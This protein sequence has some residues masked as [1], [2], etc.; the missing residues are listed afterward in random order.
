[1]D[2]QPAEVPKRRERA[3]ARANRRLLLAVARQR[4][5][6]QGVAD[7]SMQEIARAAGVGQG[8]LYRHFAHKG[9][10]CLALAQDDIAEF[11]ARLGTVIGD[12]GDGQTP[13][14][15]LEVLISERVQLM[16]RHLPL[17]AAMDEAGTNPRRGDRFRGPFDTWV[18]EQVVALLTEAAV[19]KEV[20]DL[21]VAV[22]ADLILA[23][24]SAALY[25]YQRTTCGYGQDR[26]VAAIH[27]MCIDGLRHPA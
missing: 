18:Y 5:A 13:L 7:T 12:R 2:D 15:R 11:Q 25:R 23:T 3:D 9:E 26:I 8:T 17:F 20:A 19:H 4:F 16:E 10:L 14:T 27:R 24:M 6:E 21:D 22:T 1:M